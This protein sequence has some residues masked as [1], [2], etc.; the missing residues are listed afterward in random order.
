[1]WID[2][3]KLDKEIKRFLKID[4]ELPESLKGLDDKEEHFIRIENN[5]AV[6]K[7]FLKDNY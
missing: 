3:A 5:V 7:Q 4:P 2:R 1:M 6:F